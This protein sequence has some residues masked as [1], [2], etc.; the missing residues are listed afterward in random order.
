MRADTTMPR[1]IS[2]QLIMFSSVDLGMK[3]DRGGLGREV[4]G[5]E[6][7]LEVEIATGR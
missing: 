2:A 6:H 1:V 7:L 3:R 4:E 5:P